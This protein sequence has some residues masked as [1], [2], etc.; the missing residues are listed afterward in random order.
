MT[1]D[2]DSIELNDF[3]LVKDGQYKG[4]ICRYK[5]TYNDSYLCL[6][7]ATGKNFKI[8]NCYNNVEIANEVFDNNGNASFLVPKKIF[9]PLEI[10]SFGNKILYKN[11]IGMFIKN[12]ENNLCKIILEKES[13]EKPITVNIYDIKKIYNK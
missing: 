11:D 2:I 3:V 13:E 7:S 8:Y 1:I 12:L 10:F 6:E 4:Q 9:Q 5:N